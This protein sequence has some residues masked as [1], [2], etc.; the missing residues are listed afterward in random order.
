VS[1]RVFQT[2]GGG[3]DLLAVT[4]TDIASY[5]DRVY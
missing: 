2:G 1:A 5:R 4:G 3:Q